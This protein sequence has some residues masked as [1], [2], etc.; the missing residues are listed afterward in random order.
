MFGWPIDH[1][2]TATNIIKRQVTGQTTFDDF[3]VWTFTALGFVLQQVSI[4][5]RDYIIAEVKPS[6]E[7][8]FEDLRASLERL[9]GPGPYVLTNSRIADAIPDV[10]AAI[11]RV[12]EWFVPVQQKEEVATR[13]LEH[14]VDIGLEAA[15]RTHRGFFPCNWANCRGPPGFH[16]EFFG[17]LRT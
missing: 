17:T 15:R 8:A 5:V 7:S 10:Q 1:D 12:A 6:V 13:T 16:P 4:R 11:D 14:I 9:T 2:A 3:L